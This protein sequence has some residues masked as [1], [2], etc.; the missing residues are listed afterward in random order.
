MTLPRELSFVDF[1]RLSAPY[2]HAHRGRTFVIMFGGEAVID[3]DFPH[4]VH[5]VALL[6]ALGVRLVLVHG[7]RPQIEKRLRDRKLKPRFV[8]GVR[9]TDRPT[10]GCVEDAVGNIRGRIE[11][12]LSMG[13][14]SSPMAH[15]RVRVASGN[16]VIARPWGVRGGVDFQ[17]TGSVRRIDVEAI[18]M[19]LDAGDVV[20]LSPLGYS[21]TGEI[22]NL[23]SHEVAA[24]AAAALGADKLIAL[25]EGK[26]AVDRRGRLIGQL[27]P[28]DADALARTSKHLHP[29]TTK[30]LE[31]AAKACREGVR[32]VHLVERR[33][34]GAILQELFTREGKGTL[35]T[36]EDYEGLRAARL[37]DIPG[38]L[39][40][41]GPLED[42]GFL[43]RRTRETLEQEI[44]R[45]VVIERDKMVIG[46]AALESFEPE[47]TAELYCL[48]VHPSYREGGRG[49]QLVESVAELA[50]RRGIERL[51]V[52]TTQS[53]H[54]FRERGFLPATTRALPEAR[55][56]RYDHKRRSKV[57]VRELG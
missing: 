26:G 17:L 42:Q 9:V 25:V 38:L 1:F 49:E 47:R 12:L 54:F 20:L 37:D 8:G 29:D 57:L 44:D 48:A 14:P 43:V 40:L 39:S 28:A 55:R 15:A 32:R 34:D 36:S 50:Q 41:L 56:A 4:L 6:H 53:Q 46:C 27:K 5:D 24:A 35:V 51:F 33:T 30:H 2:I 52:L 45:F 31:A 22:F 18:K 23:S 3:H 7:S 19:R 11:G 16:F 13:L 21:P 10:M